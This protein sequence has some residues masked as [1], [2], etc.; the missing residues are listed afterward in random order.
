MICDLLGTWHK[1]GCCESF[2]EHRKITVRNME[3]TRKLPLVLIEILTR[4]NLGEDDI[5][6]CH[7]TYARKFF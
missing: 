2:R 7:D 4:S 5:T 6:A 3:K 1:R